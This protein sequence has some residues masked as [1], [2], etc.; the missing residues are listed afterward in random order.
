M[1]RVIAGKHVKIREY[2]TFFSH[3]TE[4]ILHYYDTEEHDGEVF[5]LG[6]YIWQPAAHFQSMY[7]GQKI[8]AYQL[9][10]LCGGPNWHSVN[11]TITNLAGTGEI[12]DYDALNATYLSWHGIRA[13]RIAPMRHVPTLARIPQREPD[14]D[15]LFYGF[16]NARRQRIL[17]KMQTQ[18]YGRLRFLH[19]YGVFGPELDDLIARSKV[20]L[21][22][23]AFEPYHRQEQVRIFYPL[24][25]GRCVLSEKSQLNYFGDC[26]LEFTEGDMGRK[27]EEALDCWRSLGEKG[28]AKFEAATSDPAAYA[29]HVAEYLQA[30]AAA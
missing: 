4:L 13:D 19:A 26:I 8:I 20:V 14:Y 5:L 27:I 25:N 22:L 28:S 18:F 12:W 7:P 3:A 29:Q 10:Q 6:D 9:E 24:I 21:N 11:R 1:T 23:H 30:A 15:V 16:V 17:E 2:N